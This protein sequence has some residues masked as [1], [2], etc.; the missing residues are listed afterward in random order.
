M[1]AASCCRPKP[2][3]HNV[4]IRSSLVEV[5]LGPA[6]QTHAMHALHTSAIGVFTSFQKP[7]FAG[8]TWAGDLGV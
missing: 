5:P 4:V 1:G 2:I 3:N 8:T 6:W 7:H